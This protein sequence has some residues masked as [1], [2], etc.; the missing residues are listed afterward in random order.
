MNERLARIVLGVVLPA[1]AAAIAYLPYLI[2]RD[3]LPDRLA[4]HFDGSGTPDGSMTPSMFVVTTSVLLGV[5][6]VAMIAV[7]LTRR[8]LHQV[9]GPVGG[10]MGGFLAGLGSGIL[11]VTVL[12]QRDLVDWTDASSPWPMVLA[13][14][15][16][17]IAF[18]VA[19]GLLT[20]ELPIRPHPLPDP[21]AIPVMALD[22]DEHAVWSARLHNRWL[23]VLGAGITIAGVVYAVFTQWW[24]L[25]PMAISGLAVLTFTS[26][27]V[28]ADGNGLHVSYG[29]LPWP[30][31]HIPVD[32][33]ETASVI[34]IRPRDWGGWGYRG[35]LKL[36]NQAAV[37]HRAGPGL[38]LDLTDGKVFAVSV[39][40]PETPA[41]LLNA[42][43]AR[44]RATSS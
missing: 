20:S 14:L 43:V 8:P 5:G 19:A 7:A 15:V 31:T 30:R 4:T 36:M 10:A 34:D 17:S 27:R 9:A 2:Y 25:V 33:I 29:V 1:S 37:V 18:M 11:A 35:S 40:N 3:D 16:L 28:Q 13:S 26:L 38:R 21:A 6:I 24:I 39:D 41:A 12:S 23:L 32:Q 42:E 44:Q 22:A